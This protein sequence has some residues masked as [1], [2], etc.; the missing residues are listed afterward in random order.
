MTDLTQC[1][2]TAGIIASGIS[3]GLTLAYPL[4]VNKLVS[5][6]S[7]P[8]EK[9]LTLWRTSYRKGSASIPFLQIAST[10][11]FSYV[12]YKLNK[13]LYYYASISSL[14]IIGFTF[15]AI[16]PTNNQL[17]KLEEM[18]GKDVN[19]DKAKSLLCKWNKLHLV[20]VALS[21]LCYTIGVSTSMN[22]I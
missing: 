18:N 8:I 10:L 20:R 14:S 15:V 3:S 6:P 1:A 2:L 16:F 17:L 19:E 7:L 11:L 4:V 12:G 5:H 22:L 9:S 13:T 21:V